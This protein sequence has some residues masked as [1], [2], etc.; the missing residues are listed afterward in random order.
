[1]LKEDL[2]QVE[3]SE[4]HIIDVGWYPFF[5]E[6]GNFK[7]VVISEYDWENP[8]YVKKCNDMET[9]MLYMKESV[10]MVNE[11]ISRKGR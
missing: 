6:D 5:E 7:I 11:L 3:Y 4:G 8:T 1:L 10:A 2:F 9:L